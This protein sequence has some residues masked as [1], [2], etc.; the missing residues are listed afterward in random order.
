MQQLAVKYR[1]KFLDEI[2]GQPEV[3]KLR[4]FALSPYPSCWCLESAPG[5]GKTSCA[6]APAGELG[7][8]DEWSGLHTAV[9]AEFGVDAA[10]QMFRETLRM[11]PFQGNGWKVLVL[12]EMEFLSPACVNV[13]KV[14]LETQL[15]SKT[16]IVATSNDTS[17]LQPALLE[18]F[19]T[20]YFQSGP[21]LAS[22]SVP[23]LAAIWEAEAGDVPLPVDFM[24]WG[25]YGDDSFS[26]RRALDCMQQALLARSV[27]CQ[28][29]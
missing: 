5:V 9:A 21:E 13:M 7:C 29:A 28:I 4:G 12:E 1:P 3:D 15:P 25:W 8:F 22:A 2:C 24:S 11:R 19:S 18:R 17:K 20:L 10:K 16:V 6:Y 23:T 26:F 27:R 14:A